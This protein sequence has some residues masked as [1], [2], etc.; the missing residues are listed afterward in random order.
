MLAAQALE[1]AHHS[2]DF[3]PDEATAEAALVGIQLGLPAD[4]RRE[5]F[6]EVFAQMPPAERPSIM[7]FED[8]QPTTDDA[9]VLDRLVAWNGRRP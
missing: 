9:S 8:V 1:P 4:G 5:S 7:P 3:A 6:E 2:L